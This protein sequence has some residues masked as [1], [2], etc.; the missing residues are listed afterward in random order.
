MAG[1]FTSTSWGP[2]G[3]GCNST[4]TQTFTVRGCNSLPVAGLTVSV[5]TAAGGTLLASGTTNGSGQVALSWSGSSGNYYAT[6]TGGLSARFNAYAQTVAI[7]C[8]ASTTINLTPAT[9][10]TCIPTC[11]VPLADTIHASY[12]GQLYTLVYGTYTSPLSLTG[13]LSSVVDLPGATVPNNGP[14]GDCTCVSGSTPSWIAATPVGGSGLSWQLI[15]TFAKCG[16]T[17]FVASASLANSATGGGCGNIG[18]A[19]AGTTL[20]CPESGFAASGSFPSGYPAGAQP[21]DCASYPGVTTPTPGGGG[22]FTST[23]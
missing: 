19:A 10:Y 13:W 8:G 20:T 4:C 16:A 2:S 6:V 15:G 1:C 22:G 18:A 11:A 21:G 17:C 23:E 3:C 9:G 5:Y 7:N 14:G 12:A